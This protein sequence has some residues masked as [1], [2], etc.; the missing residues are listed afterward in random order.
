[1]LRIVTQSSK[2]GSNINSHIFV[3]GIVKNT[4][5][6][7]EALS[8]MYLKLATIILIDI[9]FELHFLGFISLFVQCRQLH[10]MLYS[11]KPIDGKPL[12]LRS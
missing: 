3:R 8:T 6:Q 12:P 11:V 7:I 5:Q 1:M 9:H 2:Q 10:I 4:L